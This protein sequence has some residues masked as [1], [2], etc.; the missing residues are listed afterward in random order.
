MIFE[1]HFIFQP[2]KLASL[3][4]LPTAFLEAIEELSPREH[5]LV[6]ADGVR[7]HTWFVEPL[8]KRSRLP[9]LLHFHGNAGNICSRLELLF[10]LRQAGFPVFIVDYRGYGL[11]EGK[12]SEGGLYADARA[13]WQYLT[14]V[15]SV[16]PADICLYGESLGGAVA[17]QLATEVNAGSLVL[18]G[19]FTSIAGMAAELFPFIPASWLAC[20]MDTLAK[21]G[22]IACPKLFVHSQADEIVPFGQGMALFRAA[23]EPKRFY[24]IDSAGH[25]EYLEAEGLAFTEEFRSFFLQYQGSIRR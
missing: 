3:S 8:D 2:Y 1:E 22:A 24:Q 19:T 25:N 4:E 17:A 15:L 10:A 21:I 7:L 16:L 20:K 18:Q 12:P 11:S 5:W 9:T 13:C 23:G 6:T 14:E